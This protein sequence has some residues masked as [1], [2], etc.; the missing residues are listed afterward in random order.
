MDEDSLGLVRVGNV[1]YVVIQVQA[2]NE[3]H[4]FCYVSVNLD[5]GAVSDWSEGWTVLV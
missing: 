1:A 5:S 3:F 4:T 2:A